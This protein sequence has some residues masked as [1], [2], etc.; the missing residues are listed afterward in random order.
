MGQRSGC[1][2][3]SVCGIEDVWSGA[4]SQRGN[5]Q[6]LALLQVQPCSCFMDQTAVGLV[7]S[8]SY[9]VAAGLELEAC[10]G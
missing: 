5:G 7:L 10:T 6:L 1:V 2:E 4:D 8:V 9:T 3:G